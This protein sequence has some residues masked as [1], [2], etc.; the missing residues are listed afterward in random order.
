M[1]NHDRIPSISKCTEIFGH[2]EGVEL[3][4]ALEKAEFRNA[5]SLHDQLIIMKNSWKN[6]TV[7]EIT[8]LLN[9]SNCN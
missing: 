6:I 8:K 2:T 9:I 5:V 1:N 3:Y 7:R 4:K